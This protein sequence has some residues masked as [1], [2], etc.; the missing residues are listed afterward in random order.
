MNNY[1]FIKV[2]AYGLVSLALTLTSCEKG[3]GVRAPSDSK[4]AGRTEGITRFDEGPMV[5]K[6][7][8][9]T[10]NNPTGIHPGSRLQFDATGIF[11]DGAKENLTDVVTWTASNIAIVSI[12][13]GLDSKGQVRA[14]SIGYCSITATLGDISG[15][16]TMTVN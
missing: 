4:G 9:I 1:K 14:L 2:L 8:I 3:C 10:P 12:S 16:T 7:I 13:N 11:A 15:S 6:A 5:L